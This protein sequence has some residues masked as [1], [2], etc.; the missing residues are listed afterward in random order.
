MAERAVRSASSLRVC[1]V[2]PYRDPRWDKFVAHHP[3]GLIYQRSEW[4]RLIERTY[5]NITCTVCEN[6]DAVVRGIL[7]FCVTRGLAWGIGGPRTQRRVSSLPRTP[8]GGPLVAEHGGLALLIDAARHRAASAGLRLELKLLPGTPSPSSDCVAWA[9]SYAVRL[10]DSP[11]EVRLGNA[12]SH[13]SVLRAVRKAERLGVRVRAATSQRELR[14]WYPLY[15]E[16]MRSHAQPPRP[17]GFF[18]AMWDE[19]APHGMLRLLLAE[20]TEG[21]HRRVLAGSIFLMSGQTVV[22]AENGRRTADLPYRPNDAIHWTAIQE[23]TAAGYRRYD[24]GEVQPGHEGLGRFKLKWGAE[25]I[26][27]LRLYVPGWQP[28]AVRGEERDSRPFARLWKR[29][30]LSVT[31]VAGKLVHR[32]I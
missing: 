29:V 31:A 19:L 13:A 15:L 28:P 23:A 26:P 10:P 4:L 22:F 25:A 3:D 12:R 1:E 30:P 24:L 5:G 8:I 6:E 16:T 27:M 18:S 7:P 9:T 11:G 14:Q 17:Y 20:R 32:Y 21:G 2:D